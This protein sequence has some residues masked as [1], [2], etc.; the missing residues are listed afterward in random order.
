ME[1]K[2]LPAWLAAMD[3]RELEFV[4]NFILHSGSLKAMAELYGLSY[5]TLRLRLDRLI[6]KVKNSEE[7]AESEFVDRL[8]DLTFAGKLDAAEAQDLLRLYERDRRP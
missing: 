8:K 3:Q 2:G 6:D 5:P 4:K 7:A 1:T